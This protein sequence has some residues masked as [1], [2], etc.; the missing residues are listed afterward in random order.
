[1]YYTGLSPNSGPNVSGQ[2][3]EKQGIYVP[4]PSPFA[5]SGFP[6]SQQVLPPGLAPRFAAAP[7]AYAVVSNA[8][9]TAY[10]ISPAY[11][12][13]PYT[14][15]QGIPTSTH[16]YISAAQYPGMTYQAAL[17]PRTAPPS[18]YPLQAGAPLIAASYSPMPGQLPAP[19]ARPF[20][21]SH[22]T[23]YPPGYPL[24]AGTA[25]IPYHGAATYGPPF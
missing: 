24:P 14:S 11:H 18:H 20:P 21:V 23:A 9:P 22:M 15:L 5:P 7:Q 13:I 6:P 17:G 19:A 25:P 8:G 2:T 16:A 10:T 4:A 12:S 1:M 3:V